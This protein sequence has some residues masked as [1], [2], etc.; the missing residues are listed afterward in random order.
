MKKVFRKVFVVALILSLNAGTLKAF[1]FTADG[2]TYELI[3][4]TV[5]EGLY[6]NVRLISAN[7][8]LVGDVVIP[9]IPA[10]YDGGFIFFRVTVIGNKP[11]DKC[12]FVT[13]V[14]VPR[15]VTTISSTAFNNQELTAI[16][17]DEENS[18]Y[19]SVDGMLFNKAKTELITC[20]RGKSGVITIPN[21]TLVVDAGAFSGNKITGVIIPASVQTI[22]DL[23]FE[24]CP[25]LTSIVVDE[26][27]T[28][29]SSV[30]GVLFNKDKTVIA[31][32]P[33][34][35][36][37]TAYV[38]PNTVTEI[39]WGVFAGC[40]LN[41]VTIPNSVTIIGKFS[42]RYSQI[43]SIVIPVSV[44]H[45]GMYAFD[46]CLSLKDVTV[47]WLNPSNSIFD[48]RDSPFDYGLDVSSINLHVPSGTKPAYQNVDIWKDFNILD[49]A[50]GIETVNSA[51]ARPVAYYN[52]QGQT[53][54]KEPASGIYIIKY[55]DGTAKKV[56]KKE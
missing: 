9:A 13:S 50:T 54:A 32:Y 39:G 52:L 18:N 53:L 56:L 28:A 49:D 44:T 10:T 33:A 29:F 55:N 15:T 3:S 38:I 26:E 46:Y 11:F 48:G 22:T 4:N 1:E 42:F 51:S 43:T 41:S 17:V 20:P 31:R 24:S 8:N 14:T 27:N 23:K 25:S 34:G 7:E 6:M 47:F 19:S 40:N 35:K 30:D 37:G 21:T 45:I 2:L 12:N 36:Q 5:Y 16:Y